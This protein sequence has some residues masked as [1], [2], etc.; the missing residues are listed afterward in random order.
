[1]TLETRGHIDPVTERTRS[2][3]YQ[4]ALAAIACGIF[5]AITLAVETRNWVVAVLFGLL[6]IGTVG[7]VFIRKS[8]RAVG[9]VGSSF[10]CLFGWG[11]SS[12]SWS[13]RQRSDCRVSSGLS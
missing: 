4:L 13:Q 8:G 5:V 6:T 10:G 7:I 9:P 12:L 2:A 3:P 11:S 1:M